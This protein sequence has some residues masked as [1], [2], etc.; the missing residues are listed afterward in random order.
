MF[1]LLNN[2]ISNP[3]NITHII[4]KFNL[5]LK[6]MLYLLITVSRPVKIIKTT[7]TFKMGFL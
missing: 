5:H 1:A 4:L 2:Y 7:D 6:V 3:L